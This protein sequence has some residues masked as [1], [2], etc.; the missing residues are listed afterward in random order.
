MRNVIL[1]ETHHNADVS[2]VFAEIHLNAVWWLDAAA[3]TT[4]RMIDL[5]SMDNVSILALMNIRVH[6]KRNVE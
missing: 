5:V 1:W 3:T 2:A 4:A 6:Q